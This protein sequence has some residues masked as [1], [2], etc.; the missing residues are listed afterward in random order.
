MKSDSERMMWGL[1]AE[2][3]YRRPVQP[4]MA[5]R[6]AQEQDQGKATYLEAQGT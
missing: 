3:K 6:V 5:S 4:L 1:I 2:E